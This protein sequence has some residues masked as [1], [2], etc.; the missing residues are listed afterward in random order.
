MYFVVMPRVSL[1]VILMM[2]VRYLYSINCPTV[3]CLPSMLNLSYGETP[4][5]NCGPRSNFLY[6]ALPFYYYSLCL[7]FCITIILLPLDTLIPLFTVNR[8]DWQPYHKLGAKYLFVLCRF[9]VAVDGRHVVNKFFGAIIQSVTKLASI[10]FLS[11]AFSCWFDKPWFHNWGKTSYCAHHTFL[12]GFPTGC[13]YKPSS[14]F[15]GAVAGEKEDFCKGSLTRTLFYFVL[16]LLY[17]IFACIVLLKIQK[18]LASF[19]VVTLLLLV[20]YVVP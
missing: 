4:L 18:K 19:I 11:L 14:S 8:W 10:T 12:L 2:Y 6:I 7:L 3:I 20:H 13:T 15:S 9:H 5:V 16:V 17:F 1:I